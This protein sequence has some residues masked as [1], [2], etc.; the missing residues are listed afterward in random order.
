MNV[1]LLIVVKVL[2]VIGVAFLSVFV[3]LLYK[4]IDRKLAA[5]MQGRVGPPILQPFWDVGK[6][7]QKEN[8]V[9][10]NAVV[11]LFNTVPFLA[12]IS[13]ITVMMYIPMGGLPPVL[14]GSGD[15]IVIVY[16]LINGDRW[17]FFWFAICSGGCTA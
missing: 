17:F 7:L 9:P 16:L 3:G 4:G 1:A 14:F 11:W 15:V 13:T 6:L 2:G 8:I 12:L 5:H 10:D